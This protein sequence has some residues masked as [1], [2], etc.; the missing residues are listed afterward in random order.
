MS[1]H[2]EEEHSTVRSITILI[3]I[4]KKTLLIQSSS[5]GRNR[6]EHVA[7]MTDDKFGKISE[8]HGVAQ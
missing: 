7:R 1:G 4:V 8:G 2:D 6:Q 3:L 5:R